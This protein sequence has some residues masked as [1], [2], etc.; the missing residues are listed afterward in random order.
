MTNYNEKITV[1]AKAFLAELVKI[2]QEH[3]QGRDRSHDNYY[4]FKDGD[5]LLLTG[6]FRHMTDDELSL[7]AGVGYLTS[8]AVADF[9]APRIAPL[10]LNERI[11]LGEK[12]NYWRIWAKI[13][14]VPG[15]S[16]DEISQVKRA[17]KCN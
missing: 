16:H 17:Y 11:K 15:L 12:M 6:L 2:A 14:E 5:L 10:R 8:Q 13:V 9:L 4:D 1:A 3:A 7:F